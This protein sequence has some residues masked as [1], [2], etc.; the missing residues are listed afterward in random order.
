MDSL[1]RARRRGLS[2][3]TGAALAVVIVAGGAFAAAPTARRMMAGWL[4]PLA[5]PSEKRV[6][7]LPFT[8]VGVDQALCDGLFEW[9]S[10]SLT[11]LEQF[12]GTLLVVPPSDVRHEHVASTREAGRLLGANLA[13]TGSIERVGNRVQVMIALSDTRT[14]TQLRTEIIQA[15]MPE[16]AAIQDQAVERVAR[17]LELAWKPEIAPSLQVGNTAVPAA[18]PWYLEGL[19]YL[20]RYDRPENLGRAVASFQHAVT[21]DEHYAQAY[22]GLAET[23]KRQYDLLKDTRSIDAAL[24][25]GA[26]ALAL[27]GALASAHVA[28]GMV[29]AAKG[30]YERAESEFQKALQLDPRDAGAY[31]ELATAYDATGRPAEAEATYK[32]A[33]E[34]RRDDWSCLKQLGVF[35]YNKGRLNEAAQCFREV[36]RLTPDSA[37]AHSNLG[38]TYAQMGRYDEAADELRKS[39]ALAPTSDGYDN[40][41]ATYYYAGHYRQ[42]AE[43]YRKAIELAPGNSE[44]WGNLA[45]AYRWDPALAGQ[46]PETYRHAIDMVQREITVNPGDAQLHSEVAMW[47]A[48]LGSRGEAAAEIAKALALA[49][50]DG[51]VQFRATLVYEQAGER[52]RAL[53][54][55]VAALQAGY[56]SVEFRKAPPLQA[57]R[58]D[59]RYLQ[60]VPPDIH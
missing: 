49:P 43:E 42:A 13:V 32:R 16:L 22:V 45:D 44:F 59:P 36:I 23:F 53:G 20:F 29:R 15:E 38:G 60:M 55:L 18:Y 34:L 56:P 3:R 39:L 21:V 37:K 27:N 54:T 9:V 30:E 7:V 41:G 52:D 1:P 28:M 26:R 48:A 14:V 19:G 4:Y 6:A 58:Q 11:R 24:E 33:I 35:Y 17:M 25:N 8:N 51:L 57:L 5:I 2:T 12:H 47:W 10:N 40:L 46:A 31:R 50:R